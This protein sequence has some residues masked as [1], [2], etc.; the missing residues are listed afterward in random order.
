MRLSSGTLRRLLNMVWRMCILPVGFIDHRLFMRLYTP[1]LRHRGVIVHGKPAFIAP[2]AD[3]DLGRRGLITL[4][5]RCVIS[6]RVQILTHD[7]SIDRFIEQQAGDLDD[8]VEYM[9]VS[10]VVIGQKAFIGA[11]SI[12]LPGA[13]I[14]DGAIV[15]AGSVVRGTVSPGAIVMGNPATQISTVSE[16]GPKAARRAIKTE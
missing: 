15:G 9:L 8:G 4:G 13:V 1:Y 11:G 3:L 5:D 6:T 14:G 16:W 7:F 10:G 12:L 2:T